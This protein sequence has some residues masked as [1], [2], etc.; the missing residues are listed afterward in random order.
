MLLL[1]DNPPAHTSGVATSRPTVTECG[2]EL[3]P[4]PPYSPDLAP[5]EA[6]SS[7]CSRC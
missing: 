2:Y 3:L 7:F 5:L 6:H 4:Y 1:R